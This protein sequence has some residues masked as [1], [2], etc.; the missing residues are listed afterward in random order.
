MLGG[1]VLNVCQFISL[2][3]MWPAM[4]LHVYRCVTALVQ[5]LL[6]Q[7]ISLFTRWPA[8]VQ[9]LLGL[10]TDQQNDAH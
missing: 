8:L 4:G 3:A 2:F 7:F 6:G 1:G 5:D 10:S 9:D